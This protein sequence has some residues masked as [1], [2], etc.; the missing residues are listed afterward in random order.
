[1]KK[2]YFL[3]LANLILLIQFALFVWNKFLFFEQCFE[4]L[5]RKYDV[6]DMLKTMR[7]Y[8]LILTLSLFSLIGI[9]FGSNKKW[10]F[11]ISIFYAATQLVLYFHP[12]TYTFQYAI[13]LLAFISFLWFLILNNAFLVFENKRVLK[14]IFLFIGVLLYIPIFLFL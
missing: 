14:M 12:T 1:M 13:T 5:G 7:H 3:A 2:K 6:L 8:I 9:L 10:F 4:N 11:F